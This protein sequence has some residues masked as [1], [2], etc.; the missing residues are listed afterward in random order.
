MDRGQYDTLRVDLD[1]IGGAM[2]I[3][4]KTLH[5]TG[6]FDPDYFIFAEDCDFCY[7]VRKKGYKTIYV[8]NAIIWHRGQATLNRM[9]SR[10]SYLNYMSDRSRI[11]FVLI[12]FITI[13]VLSTFLIDLI[14]F[15]LTNFDGKKT[16]LKAYWWNLKNIGVTLKRRIGYGPSPPFGCKFPVVRFRRSL[17]KTAF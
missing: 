10:G 5:E 17:K 6:L 14:W 1:Y 11:K 4:R 7:R 16:L 15:F 9:D 3:R 13:R 2:V 8:P 12:H